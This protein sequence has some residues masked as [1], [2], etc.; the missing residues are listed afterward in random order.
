MKIITNKLTILLFCSVLVVYPIVCITDQM[1]NLNLVEKKKSSFTE[2]FYESDK[3][4]YQYLGN[5]Y[6]L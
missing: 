5:I 6:F 1:Y 2:Y 4:T 3:I